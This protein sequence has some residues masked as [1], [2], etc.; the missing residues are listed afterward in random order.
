[1][2]VLRCRIFSLVAL[3]NLTILCSNLSLAIKG[4][5]KID[6][7]KVPWTVAVH[8]NP[9]EKSLICGGAIL[10]EWFVLTAAQCVFE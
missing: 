6:I 10:S 3:I 8:T 7:Q 1:M 9:G 2:F 4:G 5:E